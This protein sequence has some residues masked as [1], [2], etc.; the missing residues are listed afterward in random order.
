MELEPVTD[1]SCQWEQRSTVVT[2]EGLHQTVS[3]KLWLTSVYPETKFFFLNNP[4]FHSVN[5]NKPFVF[6]VLAAIKIVSFTFLT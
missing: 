3:P 1:R 5:N 6:H 2:D 4:T